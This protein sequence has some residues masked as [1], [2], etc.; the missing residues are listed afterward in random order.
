M[1]D[2]I[3]DLHFHQ[4]DGSLY[5]LDLLKKKGLQRRD[6]HRENLHIL[7]AMDVEALRCRPIHD[8]IPRPL[9]ERMDEMILA[10]TGGTTGSPC[11][12]VYLPE[13]FH[14]GF[15]Q[16]WLQ[17]V[18]RFHFPKNTTWLFIGPSGPHI[19]GQAARAFARSTGSLEPFAIDCDVRWVKQQQPGSMGQLLYM[20]HLIAQT[21]NII[22]QQKISVL[23]T[24]PPLLLEL[25]EK[26]SKEKRNRIKGIHTGGMT[27]DVDTTRKLNVSF[28]N[29]VLL[30]GYGNSLFGVCFERQQRPDKP[31][32]FSPHDPALDLRLIPL[33]KD[34]SAPPRLTE[35]V[36]EGERGRVM[37]HRFDQSFLL[38]N[39][40]ERDTAI[41]TP[42]KGRCALTDIGG[43]PLDQNLPKKGV[44]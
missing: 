22:N 5:W 41:F 38:L 1:F 44:Y 14:S 3:L 17:A 6:L 25:A 9:H 32:T 43:L 23:F 28:E 30:P 18:D 26:M 29:A 20:D 40:L 35:T 24:T 8:F 39:M 10:E 4:K 42:E 31:S 2:A 7:G 33:P 15:V 37:F 27:Q 11:R 12:R 36:P 19:I 13:E 21:M 34:E 16:P